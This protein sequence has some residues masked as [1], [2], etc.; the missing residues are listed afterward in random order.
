M[1]QPILTVHDFLCSP[2]QRKE[3]QSN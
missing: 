3:K 2:R 1:D